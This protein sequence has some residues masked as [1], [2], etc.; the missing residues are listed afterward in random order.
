[1]NLFLAVIII[2]TAAYMIKHCLIGLFNLFTDYTN[3]TGQIYINL[4]KGKYIV[5]FNRTSWLQTSV[6]AHSENANIPEGR[7][8]TLEKDGK[9]S[10]RIYC[11]ITKADRNDD[12]EYCEEINDKQKE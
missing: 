7:I 11:W 10:Y 5:R 8:V 1:M 9:F 12:F 6:F 2:I 4:G 3:M